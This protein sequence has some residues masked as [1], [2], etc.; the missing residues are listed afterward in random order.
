Q[1]KAWLFMPDL[2]GFLLTGE[3][4]NEYTAASTGA[5]LDA[6]TREYS[7]ELFEDLGLPMDFLQKLVKP[8]TVVGKLTKEIQIETGLGAIPVVAV[9]SHDTASAVAG[10]P[11]ESEKEIYLVCGTWCLMGMELDSP[12]INDKS[13][14]FNI[15]NE[16]GVEDK[17]RFLKNINGLWFLQQLRKG[18]NE[19]GHN[20][21]F[22]D[23]IQEVMKTDHDYGVDVADPRFLAPISMEQEIIDYCK[24]TYDVELSTIGEI[25]RAAYNGLAVHYKETMDAF[26][27]ITGENIER[28]RMVGGGIQDQFLCQHVANTVNMQVLAGPIEASALGN[29]VMQMKAVGEV[30]SLE[31]ARK[32]IASSFEQKEYRPQ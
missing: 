15:T 24:E 4:Y 3:K 25:A 31:Q 8:G 21:G 11:L 30:E 29:I 12:F 19:Q 27:E 13:L 6:N 22:P 10:T 7:K 17:I 2:F 9:G 14:E 32:M 23:I 16:G 28:L 1:G 20:L 26:A 18:W 5:V